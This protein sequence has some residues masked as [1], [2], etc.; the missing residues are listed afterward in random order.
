MMPIDYIMYGVLIGVH[1]GFL[2]DEIAIRVINRRK[3]RTE[4][5]D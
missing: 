4:N 1:V 3:E 5:D 2:F